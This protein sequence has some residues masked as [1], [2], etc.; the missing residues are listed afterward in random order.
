[1]S[2]QGL[3]PS[4]AVTSVLGAWSSALPSSLWTHTGSRMKGRGVGSFRVHP[5]PGTASSCMVL[6]APCPAAAHGS[7]LLHRPSS[8]HA[9]SL[10]SFP[11]YQR[12]EREHS[13][14]SSSAALCPCHALCQGGGDVVPAAGAGSVTGWSFPAAVG[15]ASREGSQAP[16]PSR[17]SHGDCGACS[18]TR[19][20]VALVYF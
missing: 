14:V 12:P 16:P 20:R 8:F 11:P 5:Q 19:Q 17:T 18:E 2:G 3:G 10:L 7:T 4:Y 9:L 1:M 6:R 15:G 13:V